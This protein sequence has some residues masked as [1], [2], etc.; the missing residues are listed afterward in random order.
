MKLIAGILALSLLVSGGIFSSKAMAAEAEQKSHITITRVSE[1]TSAKGS[2]N[3]FTGNVRVERLFPSNDSFSIVGA[4]VTFEPGARTAWHA[5]LTGQR[6]IITAGV[7]LVQEWGGPIVEVRPGDV[8][9]FPPGVKH[10]HG[11]SKNA[12]MTHLSLTGDR[13]GKNTEW[14]EKVSDKQ[15]RE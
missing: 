8:V 15:Y 12:A 11:A 14:L 5:H 13:D 6:L 10:W 2:D 9:W 7:G 4:Y 1:L 3:Y